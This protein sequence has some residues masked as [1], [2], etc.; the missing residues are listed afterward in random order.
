MGDK[1]RWKIISKRK[2]KMIISGILV[3][4]VIFILSHLTPSASIRSD[5]F[6]KGYFIK[7]IIADIEFNEF[8][9]NLDKVTLEDD[10]SK[11]YSVKNKGF[12]DRNGFG[13]YNFKVKKVGFLYFANAYGEA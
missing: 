4:A 3:I 13:I 7:S 11:I 9:H 5:L 12:T 1:R 10:N 2:I 8:Q 6:F